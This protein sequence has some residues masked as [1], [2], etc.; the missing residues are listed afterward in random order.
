V[1]VEGFKADRHPKI[2]VHRAANGKPFLF[3]DAPN[4]R[5][6]A[7][8]GMVPDAPVPVVHLDDIPA[9][10]DLALAIALPLGEIVADLEAAPARQ[11]L[12]PART[13]TRP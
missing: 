2:E 4:V 12:S 11:R 1:I 9:V 6:I 5:A 3:R 7:A 13:G 8:D 10:A